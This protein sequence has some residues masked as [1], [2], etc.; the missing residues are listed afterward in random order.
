MENSEEKFTL[1][2]LVEGLHQ[3]ILPF[4]YGRMSIYQA[5]REGRLIPEFEYHFQEAIAL[6]K[7]KKKRSVK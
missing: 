1:L 2:E 6:Y 4:E 5:I 3:P 7:E